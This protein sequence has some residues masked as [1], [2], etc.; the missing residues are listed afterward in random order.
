MNPRMRRTDGAGQRL[1]SWSPLRNVADR[2]VGDDAE[3]SER[4]VHIALHLAPERTETNVGTIDVL[5]HRDAR[6]PARA[7]IFV[8]GDTA[9]RLLSGGQW[10]GG[11]IRH[12]VLQLFRGCVRLIVLPYSRPPRD[13]KSPI[14][15]YQPLDSPT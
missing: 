13:G 6:S 5:D 12:G 10:C 1:E 11:S 3:A 4:L 15:R 8:I 7:H 9:L 14:A 2:A